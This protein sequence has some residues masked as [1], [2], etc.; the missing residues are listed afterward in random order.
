MISQKIELFLHLLHIYIIF[1]NLSNNVIT[2]VHK[3]AFQ[4]LL[5]LS[6]L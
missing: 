6:D 3:N 2:V 4:K 1:R 5:N